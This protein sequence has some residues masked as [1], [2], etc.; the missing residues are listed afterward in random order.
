MNKLLLCLLY[1]YLAELLQ[2]LRKL[3]RS[4]A[5]TS[6]SSLVVLLYLCS[7]ILLKKLDLSIDLIND[8]LHNF[9]IYWFDIFA[10]I[11]IF[12]IIKQI[13]QKIIAKNV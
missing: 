13:R 11:G 3:Q 12:L 1:R 7:S 8:V 6:T 9:K 2:E 10:N 4:L 5:C